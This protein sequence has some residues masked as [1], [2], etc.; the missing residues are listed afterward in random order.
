M[1]GEMVE[2]RLSGMG[3]EMVEGRLSGMGG[4][5]VEGCFQVWV[6]KAWLRR[7]RQG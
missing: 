2:G 7:R 5:M 1:G 3:G 6:R 4:D